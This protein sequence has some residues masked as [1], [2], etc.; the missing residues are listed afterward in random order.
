MKKSLQKI[1]C[2]IEFAILDLKEANKKADPVEHIV[3]M[4]LIES[5]VNLKNGVVCLQ[6]AVDAKVEIVSCDESSI[7]KTTKERAVFYTQTPSPNTIDSK[8]D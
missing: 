6:N 1:E 2:G 8:G 7:P 4:A 3:L 5:A